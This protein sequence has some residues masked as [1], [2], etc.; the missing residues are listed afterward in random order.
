[1]AVEAGV[2]GIV[3]SNHG[4]RNFDGAR[5]V[6]ASLEA[7]V[8]GLHE[9]RVRDR[10]VVLCEGGVRRGVDVLKLL[11]LG[12]DG[13]GLGRPICMSAVKG[14]AGVA[15]VLDIL[16]EEL[17]NAMKLAGCRR[18]SDVSRALVETHWVGGFL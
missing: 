4:G 15:R 3:V 17:E 16:T 11:A 1:M 5:P 12:A 9:A 7:V 10:I 8:R 18:L 2:R 13:V 14:E 6:A